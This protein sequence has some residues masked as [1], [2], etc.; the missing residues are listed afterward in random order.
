MA[1]VD[2]SEVHYT[3]TTKIHQKDNGLKQQILKNT[4]DRPISLQQTLL[5]R[6][7]KRA[8]KE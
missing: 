5:I 1:L 2:H 8:N 6:D 3:Q 7:N 4:K